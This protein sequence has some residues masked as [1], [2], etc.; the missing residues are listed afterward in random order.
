MRTAWDDTGLWTVA[1]NEATRLGVRIKPTKHLFCEMDR[2]DAR[3][4][5]HDRGGPYVLLVWAGL[6][7]DEAADAALQA[8][9]A[10]SQRAWRACAK[11]KVG[12]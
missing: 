11:R 12:A 7:A 10:V 6:S 5:Y 2:R 4:M 9:A 8:L 3:L 1:I